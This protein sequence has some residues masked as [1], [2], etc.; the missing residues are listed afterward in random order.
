MENKE[1]NK[2]CKI[3][4]KDQEWLNNILSKL[5]YS[6]RS[7]IKILKLSRTIADLGFSD[8]I[9]REHISEAIHLRQLDRNTFLN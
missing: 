9:S 3:S 8:N 5:N 1:I 2:F 7:Y 4:D 6:A